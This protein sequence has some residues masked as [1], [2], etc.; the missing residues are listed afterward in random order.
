M[1]EIALAMVGSPD[2]LP[3]DSGS[4]I[5]GECARGIALAVCLGQ[6]AHVYAGDASDHG[7]VSVDGLQSKRPDGLA[8][9]LLYSV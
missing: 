5:E 8:E 7:R 9:R 4:R 3:P 1:H 2:R 6:H